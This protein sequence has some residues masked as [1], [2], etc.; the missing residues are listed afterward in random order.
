MKFQLSPQ[1][2]SNENFLSKPP[3]DAI[4]WSAREKKR[5]GWGGHFGFRNR[6]AHGFEL[7]IYQKQKT[8]NKLEYRTSLLTRLNKF[9]PA[10]S[11][12][13]SFLH[14]IIPS[15]PISQGDTQ[16]SF[17]AFPVESPTFRKGTEQATRF[18]PVYL[19]FR[20]TRPAMKSKQQLGGKVRLP[21]L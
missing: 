16:Q 12:I 18:G 1:P 7:T 3:H 14:T 5:R 20:V 2:G 11:I 9:V 10:L 13:F 21:F 19:F 17:K 15:G 8:K 6:T 4:D